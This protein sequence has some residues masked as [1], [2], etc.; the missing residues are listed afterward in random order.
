MIIFAL[1]VLLFAAMNTQVVTVQ[2]LL[3]HVTTPLVVIIVATFAIGFL[4]GMV[5]LVP[6]FWRHSVKAKKITA[7]LGALEK[8]RDS[9]KKH[10]EGL[11]NQ[12]R[13]L[14]SKEDSPS[15]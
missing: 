4:V 9:L 2:L 14:S 7:A 15:S 1:G 11:E 8:E 13:Q 3:W 6:G 5:Q 12:L 10:S